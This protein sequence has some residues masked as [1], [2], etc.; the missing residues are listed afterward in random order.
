MPR[1]YVLAYINRSPSGPPD[2][3]SELGHAY[4]AAISDAKSWPY[5]IGD[6][7]S[8]FA[9]QYTGSPITWGICRRDV[10]SAI[11]PGDW[12]AFF[13]ATRDSIS[14]TTL[15]RFAAVMKVAIKI[16]QPSIFISHPEYCDYLNLLVRPKGRGWVH[17]EAGVPPKEWHADWLWRISDGKLRKDEVLRLQNKFVAGTALPISVGK[18]YVIFESDQAVVAATPPVVADHHVGAP[19]EMWHSD[20]ASQQIHML[21]FGSSK[22]GLRIN[23]Q[24][25]PHRHANLPSPTNEDAWVRA[26][27]AVIKG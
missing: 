13:S 11:E 26:L 21:T 18:N 8:F 20:D 4:Y 19:R 6:D 16:D 2:N 3:G 23:N 22:R 9:S 17:H 25:R 1:L 10:R 24:Q 15:Y 5:D 7:P 12:V 14:R 27:K